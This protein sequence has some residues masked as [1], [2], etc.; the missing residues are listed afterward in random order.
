MAHGR[1]QNRLAGA[2]LT[3]LAII[4][5]GALNP[6][7]SQAE[8]KAVC[9]NA[10]ADYSSGAFSV[11]SVDPVGGPRE[12]QND[13]N[14]TISDISV[15]AYGP[16]F[17]IIERMTGQNITKYDINNP[18]TPIWQYSVMDEADT[19]SSANPHSIV[20][21]SP[22][23]AYVLRHNTS[24]AWIINP[25][26]KQEADFKIG[27]LNLSAYDDQDDMGP[28][29]TTG[30]I[31][32]N[33]LFIVM[34]RL[35]QDDN[36]VPN[37]TYVAVFDTTTDQEITTGMHAT[38]KGIPLPVKNPSAICY[39]P[40]S[41]MI[42]VQGQGRLESSWSGTPAEYSGGIASI[43]PDTY[44]AALVLDDGDE[45]SHPYGN[46]SGMTI[47]SAQKGYFVSYAGWG[48]NTLYE[49][50]PSTGAV[51][52]VVHE[53]LQHKNIA[54]MEA[55]SGIDEN[56]LLWVTNITDAEIVI[57][58]PRDNSMDETFSTN[59]NPQ[60]IVFL[61]DEILQAEVNGND[62]ILNWFFRDDISNYTLLYA[63][64]PLTGE[65]EIFSMDFSDMTQLSLPGLSGG[66]SCLAAIQATKTDGSVL[67]SNMATI[68]IP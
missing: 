35:N 15:S 46:I 8:Q 29:M 42:Y 53:W 24:V 27:T 68:N 14:P 31:V 18:S 7:S 4:I 17:Y 30:V 33:K 5:F 60:K 16:Y 13:I 55:G 36:W 1:L 64:P 21:A 26:A 52:G 43:N 28:E 3:A 63:F 59:L 58:D 44:A 61:S 19:V 47:L 50:N 12:V 2:F 10:A 66:F 40:V 22:T 9:V 49:F 54:G 34:Q 51:A 57:I 23:K 25:E 32:G 6:A 65:T 39:E 62:L 11:V 41:K 45:N 48:D 67:L 20:F 37:E 38:L 56:G